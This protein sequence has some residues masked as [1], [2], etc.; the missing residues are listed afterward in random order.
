MENVFYCLNSRH[1]RDLELVSSLARVSNRGGLNQ[2][3]V[4]SSKGGG[5]EGKRRGLGLR[6]DVLTNCKAV[7]LRGG[8]WIIAVF[9]T[10]LIFLDFL[11]A[12]RDPQRKS[13]M[14]KKLKKIISCIFV[15]L[16]YRI[17]LSVLKL[18]GKLKRN[19]VRS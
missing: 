5:G 16:A 14:L 17:C 15:F 8:Q 6:N 12:R 18:R 2:T 7:T 4:C 3:N 9:F 13:E 1:C 10:Q 11:G 19:C